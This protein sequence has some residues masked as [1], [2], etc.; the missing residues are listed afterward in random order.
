M[1]LLSF[2]PLLCQ[3]QR[4]VAVVGGGMS[5]LAV[6]LALLRHSEG[7]VSVTVFDPAPP[8]AVS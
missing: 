1:S 5:G 2:M 3:S 7:R 8:G 4:H 6:A